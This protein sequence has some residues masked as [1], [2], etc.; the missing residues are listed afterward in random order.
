[1]RPIPNQP[2]I[3]PTLQNLSP[4]PS[5]RN[6]NDDDPGKPV[7]IFNTDTIYIQ[8]QR[9]VTEELVEPDLIDRVIAGNLVIDPG[10]DAPAYWATGGGW[11]ISG[12]KAIHAGAGPDDIDT[13]V[14]I[15]GGIYILEYT[16]SAIGGGASVTPYLGSVSPGN[17]GVTRS[18]TGT[19]RENIQ[20]TVNFFQLLVFRASGDVTI[21]NIKLYKI[22]DGDPGTPV[23]GWDWNS[24]DW[25]YT[26]T[27]IIHNA[28]NTSALNFASLT[29]GKHYRMTLEFEPSDIGYCSLYEDGNFVAVAN[30]EKQYYYFKASGTGAEIRPSQEFTGKI[31]SVYF[32]EIDSFDDY[33]SLF[34]SSDPDETSFNITSKIIYEEEFA[35]LVMKPEDYQEGEVEGGINVSLGCGNFQFVV[36]K[37]GEGEVAL[38]SNKIELIAPD[39]IHQ[40]MVGYSPCRS[41][42]F[43]FKTFRLQHRVE[44]EFSNP[45]FPFTKTQQVGSDGK[46]SLPFAQR[47]KLW[48]VKT[49]MLDESAHSCIT[50][51]L[52]CQTM[53]IDGDQYYWEDRNYAIDWDTNGQNLTA[54]AVF[55]LSDVQS[56]IFGTNSSCTGNTELK[57]L[58]GW[59]SYQSFKQLDKFNIA[60]GDS[61]VIRVDRLMINGVNQISSPQFLRI[62]RDPAGNFTPDLDIAVGI[63]NNW[64]DA[65]GGSAWV[66]N[67]D[68][69][70]NELIT[71]GELKFYD[72]LS[73]IEIQPGIE[74]SIDI[75]LKYSEFSPEWILRRYTNE[76]MAILA[77]STTPYLNYV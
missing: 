13:N 24:N 29:A 36:D 75:G 39:D 20:R 1:M 46:K 5:D 66:Q 70:I 19:Y 67:A 6:R 12:G 59:D 52:A 68:Q 56:V 18:A 7:V 58:K 63:N 41:W 69:F 73:V 34:W 62:Y 71:G 10:F 45:T 38:N 16:V 31:T 54:A 51:I 64:S 3:F 30:S 2:F 43:N 27:G 49:E 50:V 33:Y 26:D 14:A 55:Q 4:F 40:M 28:G 65:L 22:I 25:R 57:V 76:G 60:V 35:T 48:R 53:T 61:M 15:G 37:D 8:F 44:L 72:A 9:E 32:Q 42:G 17:N 11:S 77:S 74:F 21:D 23:N 47:D